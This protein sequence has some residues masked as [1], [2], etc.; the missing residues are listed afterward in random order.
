V[1]SDPTPW[2]VDVET[3]A[4]GRRVSWLNNQGMTL[5]EFVVGLMLA[6][7]AGLVVFLVMDALRVPEVSY[8]WG[9]ASYG[10]VGFWLQHRY[11]DSHDAWRGPAWLVRRPGVQRSAAFSRRSGA[12][13]RSRGRR[14][15]LVAVGGVGLMTLGVG[16]EL[17][18]TALVAD[19]RDHGVRAAAVAV[20][21]FDRKGD[22]VVRFTVAGRVEERAL[23]I[24]DTVPRSRQ[25]GDLVEVVYDAGDPGRVL[26]TSQMDERHRLWNLGAATFGGILAIGGTSWWLRK[27]RSWLRGRPQ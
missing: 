22:A 18:D 7:F 24:N 26:L 8:V 6:L 10:L 4:S 19:L 13:W 11:F 16:Y 17:H 25:R 23:A 2:S 27:R 21:D 15:L 3:S 5:A 20:D 12:W 14:A 9:Y 1:T